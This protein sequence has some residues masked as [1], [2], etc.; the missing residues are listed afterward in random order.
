MFPNLSPQ[1]HPTNL[2]FTPVHLKL[3][4][5]RCP[6]Y[7]KQLSGGKKL[8]LVQC[9]Y[10]SGIQQTNIQQQGDNGG[11]NL[12]PK[13]FKFTGGDGE[14]DDNLQQEEIEAILVKEDVTLSQLP[15]ELQEALKLGIVGA[16][17]VQQWLAVAGTP[18]IGWICKMWPGFRERVLGNPRFL[19]ALAIE[20]IIGCSAKFS[21][22][23][24]SRGDN[25]NN[26]LHF[27]ASDMVLEVVGDFFLVWLLSPRRSWKPVPTTGI[28]STIAKLPSHAFQRGG[29]SVAQ[30]LGSYVYRAAQFFAVGLVSS[31]LGHSFTVYMV[32]QQRKQ[33]PSQTSK[34]EKELAPV[35]DNSLAWGS[36]LAWNATF[37]YNLVN[38]F[39]DQVLDRVIH[40]RL[41]KTIL[42]F[43]LRFANT[44]AGGNMWIWY[45]RVVGVQ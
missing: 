26:E 31:L 28:M 40:Q 25:F 34:E 43:T 23:I 20:E 45:A 29:F 5:F 19:L 37:R 1:C 44:F 30:R 33:N 13:H 27:V 8:S 7:Y 39:E 35:L 22:E 4:N 38:G 14:G 6:T 2:S 15:Q 9:S 10:T 32:E 21:A 42:V 17:D 24:K 11:R 36:F 18:I 16:K 3:E 41:L 12:P